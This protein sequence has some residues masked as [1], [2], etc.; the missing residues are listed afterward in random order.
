MWWED[1]SGQ[2]NWCGGNGIAYKSQLFRLRWACRRHGTARNP[3][4][5]PDALPEARADSKEFLIDAFMARTAI[6]GGQVSADRESM[7][8]DLLLIR[9]RLMA[10]KAIDT[11]PGVSGHLVFMHDRVLESSVTFGAFP[12][13]PDKVGGRLSRFDTR[14][15]SIHKKAGQN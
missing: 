6:A 4:W 14:T 12:G 9:G 7:M 11:L 10:V 15:R 3:M 13:G 2:Q 8:I 1:A 5:Q